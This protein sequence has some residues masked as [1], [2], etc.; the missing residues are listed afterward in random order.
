MATVNSATKKTTSI[1]RCNWYGSAISCASTR[2]TTY[3]KSRTCMTRYFIVLY[4]AHKR[5]PRQAQTMKH[6]PII[7]EAT[8]SSML[9][10]SFSR[11][12]L[13]TGYKN[14]NRQEKLAR[15]LLTVEYGEIA[16][17][18]SRENILFVS[19]PLGL[20]KTPTDLMSHTPVSADATP[21]PPR[22][23]AALRYA[24]C[25]FRAHPSCATISMVDLFAFELTRLV[26]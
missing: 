5:P 21:M 13:F 9:T 15:N 22:A 4:L 12:N 23:E 10:F 1:A 14:A 20:P 19:D 8:P 16:S 18:R 17:L 2:K 3:D 7:T 24:P 25:A 11:Y 6:A 26:Y